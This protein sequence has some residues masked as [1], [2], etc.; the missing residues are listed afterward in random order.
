MASRVISAVLTLKDKNFGSGVKKASGEMTDFQRRVQQTKNNIN[1]F[2]Q[3]SVSS[4]KNIGAVAGGVA[5]TGIAALGVSVAQT[6][7]EM[8]KAFR[9]LGAQT[10]ATGAQL[11]AMESTVKE[12]F[13]NGYGES[14]G[15]LANDMAVLKQNLGTV[16]EKTLESAQILGQLS[17]NADIDSV[18]RALRSMT[19][20]FP[21]A[22][23][24]QS[25]DLIT[26]TLQVGG[27]ASGDLL[28]TFNEYSGIIASTGIEMDTFANIMVNGAKAG[29]RNYDV[30][31]DTLKEFNILAKSGSKDT[32]AAFKALGM[33]ASKV[34]ADL[35]AGGER[36]EKAYYDT[37][38]ALSA[39]D[40][41][42]KY[43]VGVALMGTK[44]ED[45]EVKTIEALGTGID[46]L[47][48]YEGATQKAGKAIESGFGF[49]MNKVWNDIKVGAA[50]AFTNAGGTEL[51][52][53]LATKAEEL[54][55]KIETMVTKAT[56]FANA[57]RDNWPVIKEVMIGVGVFAGTLKTI[58]IGVAAVTTAQWLWNAAMAANP[59]TWVVLGIAG[60]VAAGVLLYRNW[61]TVRE[62]T[63][64]LWD[65]LGEFKG[66]ANIV[67]G[68]LDDLIRLAVDLGENWDSTKGIWEN[69]W[70]SMTRVATT[71]V[72]E[73]I[74]SIN[75]I[76]NKLGFDSKIPKVSVPKY[77]NGTDGHPGGL[78]ILGDGGQRELFMTPDG[79][80]GL[81]P[82]VDTLMDLPKGTQV[83]SGKD[84]ANLLGV[85]A[86]K[87]GIGSKIKDFASDI[88]GFVSDPS[89]L[90]EKALSTFGVEVPKMAG[91]FGDIAKGSFTF[92]KNKAIEF[93]T[94]KVSDFGSFGNVK[95]GIAAPSQ[96]KAWISQALAITGTPM[97]W[98]PA[99]LIKAQKESGFN[100]RA[101]NLWDS[102][103][104]KG[105]PSKGLF[106]TIDPTF[107]AY[108]MKGMNDIWNPVHNAVA[109]IRYIKSRYGSVFNTPG[110]K[111]MMRGGAYR[112]YRKGGFVPSTQT[113]W[114]GEEG[115]ELVQ[116]PG[117][118]RVYNNRDSMKMTNGKS[119]NYFTININGNKSVNEILNELI[120]E[121]KKRLANI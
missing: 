105:T 110:I 100:P 46:L 49:R 45:L 42:A 80:M 82:A 101:I 36:G 76:L 111:S 68:P 103:A 120:P 75:W 71:S 3:S 121:L 81:S 119:I 65:K 58:E 10:G 107:N 20:S 62:K 16:D 102:N 109:A 108:K 12:A 72:N 30:V 113:A 99:M 118:S 29:A 39:L 19:A 70:G 32:V 34:A 41:E 25:M 4:L 77:A 90:F 117:G 59:V 11:A 51:L 91:V 57:I 116:L 35:A 31:A 2:S 28:D 83:L 86:Y 85:P 64:N 13:R 115:P 9:K 67:L 6:A 56:D 114:V 14:I 7:I 94:K 53:G 87:E 48:E 106:Q 61:D 60:L 89:K 22:T 112:G 88:W 79:Q 66:I 93:V 98:M 95:G 40:D 84:T 47:G 26:R 74:G 50:E 63:S 24:Q 17:E 69:V 21:G 73:I 33:D 55:P 54:A 15:Q 27:D 92:I 96:V 44:F 8:D 23:Q 78:A 104:K 1:D 52:D 97:S 18:A 37:M 43:S 5:A 38:K